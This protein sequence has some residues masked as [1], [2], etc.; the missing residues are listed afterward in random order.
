[1]K[2]KIMKILSLCILLLV[3]IGCEYKENIKLPNIKLAIDYDS[4]MSTYDDQLYELSEDGILTVTLCRLQSTLVVKKLE[5]Q[6]DYNPEGKKAPCKFKV[7]TVKLT[8]KQ[9]RIIVD[10]WSRIT[11]EETIKQYVHI[12]DADRNTNATVFIEIEGDIPYWSTYISDYEASDRRDEYSPDIL[13]LSYRFL[14]FAPIEP[15]TKWIA[16][17]NENDGVTGFVIDIEGATKHTHKWK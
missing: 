15:R 4:P 17:P 14:D 6:N 7:K 3:T 10:I 1:M 13:D 16:G 11:Q 12:L 8:N 5:I 2:Y 9:K